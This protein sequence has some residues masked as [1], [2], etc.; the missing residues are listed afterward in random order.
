MCPAD[1]RRI[2]RKRAS[3]TRGVEDGD[4]AARFQR[5]MDL[6]YL[7]C[8]A[9]PGEGVGVLAA[10]SIGEPSTQMTLNTFHMAGVLMHGAL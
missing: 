4:P 3:E 1:W 10:Q 2:Q 7:Q 8:Q 9:Q 6:K 5:L